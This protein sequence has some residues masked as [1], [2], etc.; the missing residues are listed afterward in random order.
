MVEAYWLV[1]KY[2]VE[3]EQNGQER[4]AYGTHLLKILSLEL[5]KSF[6]KGFDER[7]LRKTRQFYLIFPIRDT[8]CAELGWSH[9]SETDQDIARYSIL[10]GNEQ[11]FATK[12]KLFL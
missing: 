12:Y 9:Y 6:G 7:E 10:N 5:S 1:G 3:E 2:I 8:M 4:V 11:I